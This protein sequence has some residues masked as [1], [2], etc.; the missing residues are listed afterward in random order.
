MSPIHPL[1]MLF[2]QLVVLPPPNTLLNPYSKR[3]QILCR[4][5]SGSSDLAGLV[6]TFRSYFWRITYAVDVELLREAHFPNTETVHLAGNIEAFFPLFPPTRLRGIYVR[7]FWPIPATSRWL[8]RH[9]NL[10]CL[11]LIPC[12][13]NK[14][15]MPITALPQLHSLTAEYGLAR[16]ILLNSPALVE[17]KINI[18][19]EVSEVLEF[20]RVRCPIIRKLQMT[21]FDIKL[22][23]SNIASI[24][25]LPHVQELHLVCAWD[26][27]EKTRAILRAIVR[28]CPKLN[29]FKWTSQYVSD[30]LRAEVEVTYHYTLVDGLWEGPFS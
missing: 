24:R 4:T 1:E 20:L 14:N 10:R 25:D 11:D 7:H 5:L 3:C 6:R 18:D 15:E 2:C 21:C 27:E 13:G 30:E 19:R 8:Q 23:E 17:L 16:R 26:P 29:S 28:T 12:L 9:T 22:S